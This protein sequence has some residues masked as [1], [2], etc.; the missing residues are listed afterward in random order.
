MYEI[1]ILGIR[2]FLAEKLAYVK[3]FS[4]FASSFKMVNLFRLLVN[5]FRY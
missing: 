5:L 4:I 3:F 2:I 1:A